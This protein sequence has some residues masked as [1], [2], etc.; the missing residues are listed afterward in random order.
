M[1]CP[2]LLK[3]MLRLLQSGWSGS[4]SN[5]AAT[6]SENVVCTWDFYERQNVPMKSSCKQPYLANV[7]ETVIKVLR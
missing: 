3:L 7:T 1:T 5:C 6:G 4:Y 2:D